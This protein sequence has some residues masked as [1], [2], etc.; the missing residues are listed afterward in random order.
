DYAINLQVG[1]AEATFIVHGDTSYTRGNAA[2][3]SK[4]K[5]PNPGKDIFVQVPTSQLGPATRLTLDR[6][7]RKLIALAKS[8]ALPVVSDGEAAGISAWTLIDRAGAR[9]GTF[10]VSKDTFDVLRVSSGNREFGAF[11]FSGWNDTFDIPTPPRSLVVK[12]RTAP[13]RE[14]SASA[15]A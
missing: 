4:V 15:S 10:S 5:G 9:A 12:G 2:F 14:A 13:A 11:T 1:S 3:W 6:T 7:L 8:R